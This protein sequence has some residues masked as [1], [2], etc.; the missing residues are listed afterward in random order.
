[1]CD[2][3]KKA[4]VGPMATVAGAFCL[5]AFDVVSNKAHEIVI[6][7]GGDLLL[8]TKSQ[9]TIALYAGKSELSM[10][11]GLRIMPQEDSIGICTSAGTIGHS[12]SFGK[13]DLALVISKDV[14]L[15]DALATHL[16]NLVKT[17]D[18]IKNAVEKVYSK[19]G[20][21][22]AI[23]IIDENIAAIG[24]IDIIPLDLNH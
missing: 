2:A 9:R 13:A 15:A 11:L 20:V 22:G 6:E 7:N 24:D 18:D 10:K 12:K 3:S 19:A 4:G 23:V 21:I 5:A 16:G 8:R 14:L 1:M 17:K